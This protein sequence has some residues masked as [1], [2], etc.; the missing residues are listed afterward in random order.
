[1]G[2]GYIGS[3]ATVALQEAGYN[4]LILDNLSNSS[5]SV[6]DAIASITGKKPLFIEGDIRD[7]A[8]LDRLFSDYR[9]SAVMHFAGLKAVGESVQFPLRYYDN[10]VH[11]SIQLLE[12]MQAANVRTFIFSSSATVY[13]DPQY[14]PL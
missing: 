8:C 13:G 3:H 2:T 1:G 14:L 11:G 7:R 4:V 9:I 12:A 10:N 5:A 6:N